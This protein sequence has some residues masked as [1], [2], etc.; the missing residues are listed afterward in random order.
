[1]R[2]QIM[3]TGLALGLL[4]VP[5]VSWAYSIFHSTSPDCAAVIPLPLEVSQGAPA[6]L[7][8]CFDDGGQTIYGI[9]MVVSSSGSL[10]FEFACPEPC[11]TNP[12]DTTGSITKVNLFRG[13]DEGGDVTPLKI[14]TFVIHADG[15]AGNELKLDPN[16]PGEF[17]NSG[18][19]TVI[20]DPNTVLA[21]IGGCG[22]G[23]R[24][25]GEECDGDDDDQC[26]G[27]C[28]DD[29]MCGTATGEGLDK[30]AQKCVN[31]MNKGAAKVAKAQAGD[32]AAC[33][34]NGG[35]GKLE[36]GQTIEQCITSDPKH[37]VQKAINKIKTSDCSSPPA[38][39]AVDTDKDSIGDTMAGM[40][41][42][43]IHAI[44]GDLDSGVIVDAGADKPGAGCQAAIAKAVSKCQDA[45]LAVFNSCKK[46]KLKGKE[47]DGIAAAENSGELQ[48]ECL[49]ADG[50]GIPDGKRKM[51][52]KCVT[53]LSDA[54]TKKCSVG[55]LGQLIPG[56][57]PPTA[58][59]LDQKIGC[60]VCRALKATDGLDR[61]CDQFHNGI[62]DGSCP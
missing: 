30:P 25:S 1:M 23:I 21:V 33:I 19:D 39:P 14:G 7:N 40:A 10:T 57:D 52:K 6:N 36:P 24:D 34:K 61:T 47:K 50:S 48:D 41:R 59:C 18:F 60:E 9:S 53:G 46:N 42:D 28:T 27:L 4:A 12:T 16:D 13:D 3:V 43:V 54:L 45:K 17:L 5:A 38:F 55:N 15:A 35:K 29:C 31:S 37:K 32:N 8:L 49:P 22:D 58:A 20:L 2:K 26:P 44:F 56:C 51:F 62:V 11:T